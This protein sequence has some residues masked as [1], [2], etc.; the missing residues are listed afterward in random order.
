[1]DRSKVGVLE[2]LPKEDG[3]LATVDLSERVPSSCQAG[4]LSSQDPVLITLL[5]FGSLSQLQRAEVG[6]L[7]WLVNTSRLNDTAVL[8]DLYVNSS[9]SAVSRMRK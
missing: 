6:L 9:G 7:G 8:W 2:F 4:S 5:G 1:V 3:G